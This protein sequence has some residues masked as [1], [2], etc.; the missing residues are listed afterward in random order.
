ML[1]VPCRSCCPLRSDAPARAATAARNERRTTPGRKHNDA[2]TTVRCPRVH[3]K[4]GGLYGSQGW[5]QPSRKTMCR[6]VQASTHFD[7]QP[8]S[9]RNVGPFIGHGEKQPAR[10]PWTQAKMECSAT[11]RMELLR[12]DRSRCADTLRRS[13]GGGATNT[14]TH[15]CRSTPDPAAHHIYTTTTPQTLRGSRGRPA[16][17]Q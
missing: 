1:R 16:T 17:N 3:A 8:T 13:A 4:T 5:E 7:L 9:A 11:S 2:R 10:N 6:V 12:L 14:S 15:P